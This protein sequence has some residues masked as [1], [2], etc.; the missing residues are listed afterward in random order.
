M[1]AA[2][3]S[4]VAFMLIVYVVLD[5]RNFG[6]EC[7]IGSWPRRNRSGD[8]S[9]RRSVH[10]GPGTKFGSRFWRHRAGV[11]LKLLASAFAGYYLAALSHLWC[12]YCVDLDRSR[13]TST[14]ACGRGLILY[15]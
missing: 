6:A 13:A 10:S 5:G 3:Y 8:K 1:I 15:S 4:I 2:W 7:C 14:I 9:S 12:S 11:F